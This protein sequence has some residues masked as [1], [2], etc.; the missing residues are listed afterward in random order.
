MSTI[1][2]LSLINNPLT[3]ITATPELSV[4]SPAGLP[5]SVRRVWTNRW[6]RA[7]DEVQKWT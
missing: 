2:N 5:V 7:G 6:H 4:T 1:I 3:L